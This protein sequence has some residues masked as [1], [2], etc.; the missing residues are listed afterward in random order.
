MNQPTF[1][2]QYQKIVSAY[3]KNEL[4]PFSG[5]ACFIGNLLNN[6]SNWEGCRTFKSQGQSYLD[7][8]HDDWVEEAR[9]AITEESY[10]LYTPQDII[11]LENN[12]LKNLDYD[13]YLNRQCV[14]DEIFN[15]MVSTLEMLRK[16]HES[17]GEIVKDYN[18]TKRQLQTI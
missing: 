4:N 17:K 12:F 7:D 15:A 6:N 13:A 14:E 1:E 3:Y 9:W 10:G 5:C 11:D 18:F 8:L 16:I 2:Q